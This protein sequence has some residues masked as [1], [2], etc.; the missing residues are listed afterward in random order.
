MSASVQGKTNMMLSIYNEANSCAVTV[1]VENVNDYPY[2]IMIGCVN[3][4]FW[5]KIEPA[6]EL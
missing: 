3:H 6:S 1:D 2:H 4:Y 5:L